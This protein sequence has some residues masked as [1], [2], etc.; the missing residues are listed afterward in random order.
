MRNLRDAQFCLQLLAEEPSDDHHGTRIA[1]HLRPIL[2]FGHCFKIL[3]NESFC[4]LV[5]IF[6]NRLMLVCEEK[7]L[8]SIAN[9]QL[10]KHFLFTHLDQLWHLIHVCVD[11]ELRQVSVA[12]VK[13][14]GVNE[15]QRRFQ[16]SVS[17]C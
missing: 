15:A 1:Q 10:F 2:R 4:W 14:V 7:Q 8:D 17:F 16:G 13:A 6:C 12:A 11:Q 9:C 3:T 5:K